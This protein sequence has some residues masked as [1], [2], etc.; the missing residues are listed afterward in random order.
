MINIKQRMKSDSGLMGPTHALSAVA[1]SFLLTWL[2]SDFMFNRVLGTKDP[3]VYIAATIII[4]GAALMPD[5][6]AVNSTSINVL[7]VVGVLL[8]KSMRAFSSLIQGLVRSKGDGSPGDPHRGFWHTF[9]AAFL[10]GLGTS[11]LTSINVKLFTILN[12]PITVATFSVLFILY[13]S[14]QLLMASLFKAFY[15]KTKKNM[16]GAILLQIG[17]LF[18]SFIIL[19]SLPPELSYAWVGAAVTLGWVLHLFGDMLTVA[20]VPVLW[21]LKYRGKR[22]WNFRFPFNI[23]AGGFIENGLLVPLFTIIL[24]LSSVKVIAIL[25]G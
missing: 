1:I 16:S 17:S 8:S 23:K 4:I 19:I 14:L 10:V 6:D 7:G 9:A 5:L 24:I 20:G 25:A 22:W 2:A 21:P 3:I 13:I 15:K 11:A 12:T 18:V